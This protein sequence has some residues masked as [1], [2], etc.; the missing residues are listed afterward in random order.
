MKYNLPSFVRKIGSSVCRLKEWASESELRKSRT[1]LAA[2]LVCA[3]GYAAIVIL[4]RDLPNYQIFIAST[5]PVFTAAW[6]FGVSGALVASGI[7]AI[8]HVL[9]ILSHGNSPIEWA[10]QGGGAMGTLFTMIVGSLIGKISSLRTRLATE[11]EI[12]LRTQDVTIFALAHEAELRDRATGNHLERTSEYVRII[13]NELARTPKYSAYLASSYLSDLIR[14]A[15][16]HDIG[17]VGVP[18]SILLKPGSLNP[19]E[20]SIIQEHCEL[21]ARV[22]RTAEDKLP[23]QS[24]LKI[25]VQLTLN[26]HEKWDGS[27]YPAGLVGESIPLSGRIMAL[28]DV[29]DALRSER[30]YKHAM[31]HLTCCEIIEGDRDTHF[32]PD[33]VDAFFRR[34]KEFHEVSRNL[35]DAKAVVD[36]ELIEKLDVARQYVR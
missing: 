11:R 21:G 29:Y 30:S 15:P 34:H 7:V 27:G 5:V 19:T 18:D 13:A 26:H 28:A 23:F 3:V 25:A 16:L 31:D 14:S 2:V 4:F 12:L 20:F 17:K 1:K 24:F 33:L 8:A 6:I 10:F 9:V 36:I 35:A 22:L 32:D